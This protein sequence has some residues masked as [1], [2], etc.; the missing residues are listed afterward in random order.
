M[1][2]M[3]NMKRSDIVIAGADQLFATEDAVDQ[4]LTEA[5]QLVATLTRLRVGNNMSGVWGQN[6]MTEILDGITALGSARGSIIRAHEH[7]SEIRSQMGCGAV[8]L[9]NAREKPIVETTG[10]LETYPAPAET[11]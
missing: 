7:L 3:T 2:T 8:A 1:E 10:A 4:A 5:G 6:A 9:G 11:D